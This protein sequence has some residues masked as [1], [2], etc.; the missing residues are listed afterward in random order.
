[1]RCPYC[2]IECRV[3]AV[4]T[5]NSVTIRFYCRNKKCSH[6]AKDDNSPEVA[7]KNIV[8]AP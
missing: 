7:K 2:G 8:K 1:M 5:E 3:K 4:E 6:Y